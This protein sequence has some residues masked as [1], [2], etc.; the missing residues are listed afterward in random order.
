[1][2]LDGLGGQGESVLEM[3]GTLLRLRPAGTVFVPDFDVLLVADAHFG[4]DQAF[5]RNGVPVPLGLAEDNLA[6]LTREI[7]VTGARRLVF[8][9][10]LLHARMG[11]SP[12][13]NEAIRLWRQAHAE[14]SVTLVRGNHDAHSG[15]PPLA[16][17]VEAVNEPRDL[18]P[19]ALCHHPHRIPGRYALA[20][21]THPAVVVRRG[22]QRLRLPCFHFGAAVGVLPAFGAF[23]GMHTIEPGPGDPVY[24]IAGDVVRLVTVESRVSGPAP[25][26]GAGADPKV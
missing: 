22:R 6:R 23:T 17:G 18:G 5:R 19:F 8:L 25:R 1:M 16:W 4:K 2:A 12:S 20:G 3:A 15:D 21:H 7:H 10:D 13:L 24:A 9:G 14:L 11:R 26:S